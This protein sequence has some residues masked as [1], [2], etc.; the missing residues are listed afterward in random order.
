[1]DELE[2]SGKRYISTR[3]AGKQYQ[4]HSDYIG[5]LIRGGKVV[6]KKVGRSWYVD[7]TSLAVY[8][9]KEAKG[10]G[11]KVAE[12]APEPAP[13]EKKTEVEIEVRAPMP[14][15]RKIPEVAPA[16]SAIPTSTVAPAPSTVEVVEEG[17]G[18]EVPIKIEKIKV[19][20]KKVEKS[21]E[22][23]VA[24]PIP[25]RTT[26]REEKKKNIVYVSDDAPIE[27]TVEETEEKNV[28]DVAPKKSL[29]PMQYGVVAALGVLA[30]I[31][32][33]G[34]SYMLS[35]KATVEGDQMTATVTLGK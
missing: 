2:I 13:V 18:E 33:G 34:M 32:V 19:E 10:E 29:R 3:R 1:M 16:I 11:A 6:G 35:Y 24:R 17:D 5:Q 30:F 23:E 7:E 27:N 15:W 28:V 22:E 4:Y 8:L 12:I 25:I 21:V 14:S 26:V 9:G 20:E 31:I